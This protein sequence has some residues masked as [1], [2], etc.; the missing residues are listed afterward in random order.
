MSDE[1]GKQLDALKRLTSVEDDD[2]ALIA[3]LY[4][5]AI[6]EVLDYTNRDKMLDNMYVYAKKIAKIAFNQL[7]VEGE[8]ARTEGGVVQ[9]FE[10][11]IPASIRSKLNRYRIAKV[12]S[13]Y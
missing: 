3:D 12:R 11:G 6:T 9:N 7:D 2:S 8:T 13:L 10:V 5:D 1:K 4:D